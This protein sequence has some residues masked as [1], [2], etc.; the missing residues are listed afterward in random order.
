MLQPRT[1]APTLSVPLLE[2]GTWTA[3]ERSPDT[4][5]VVVFYR[6]KHCPICK[7]YLQ[8]VQD[9]LD[10]LREAGAEIVA[11]SMDSEERARTS[12]QEWGLDRLPVGYGMTEQTA[13]DWGLYISSARP[14]SEEPEV[15]SEPGLVVL[16]PGG[17][18]FFVQVQSAPFTRPPIDQLIQGLNFVTENDYPARGDLTKQA[19]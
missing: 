16:R 7:G 17:E 4:F 6:G 11:V 19:A 1:H 9:H 14:G 5:S 12:A 13:R 10:G 18:I 2:G 3:S 8:E 15:F